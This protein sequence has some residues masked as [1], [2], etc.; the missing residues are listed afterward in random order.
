[1]DT[2]P[3]TQPPIGLH[4]H[5]FSWRGLWYVIF[6]VIG[7]VYLSALYYP[8]FGDE[9]TGGYPFAVPTW[10]FSITA[11]KVVAMIAWL[12][13]GTHLT[14]KA[15]TLRWLIA[16]I[17]LW[18]GLHAWVCVGFNAFRV[19]SEAQAL[20]VANLVLAG[21]A[22]V[23]YLRAFYEVFEGLPDTRRFSFSAVIFW[24]IILVVAAVALSVV[25]FHWRLHQ[26]S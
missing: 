7:P 15:P 3:A 16:V 26:S 24:A 20:H 25:L 22:G 21:L 12:F 6:A 8:V 18:G 1:M 9:A 5:A 10:A 2:E 14:H 13:L 4:P 23:F 19:P 11:A 17:F